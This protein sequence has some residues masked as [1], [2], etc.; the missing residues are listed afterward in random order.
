MAEWI[1]ID[2][3][4][5]TNSKEVIAYNERDKEFYILSYDGNVW[6]GFDGWNTAEGW[7]IKYWHPL[8]EPPTE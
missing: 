5:P 1:S 3:S 8:T 2:E 4:L 6:W 7:G